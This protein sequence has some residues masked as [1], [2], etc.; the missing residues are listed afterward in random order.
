MQAGGWSTIAMMAI[1][2][3]VDDEQMNNEFAKVKPL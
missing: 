1:Y 3:T 2:Q